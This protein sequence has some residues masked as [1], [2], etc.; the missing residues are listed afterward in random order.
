[1]NPLTRKAMPTTGDLTTATPNKKGWLTIVVVSG[2]ILAMAT[3]SLLVVQENKTRATALAEKHLPLLENTQ[4]LRLQLA[5]TQSILYA[6]YLTADR[7]GFGKQFIPNFANLADSYKQI[8]EQIPEARGLDAID[9]LIVDTLDLSNSFDRVMRAE[10]IDWDQARAVLDEFPAIAR[11]MDIESE[12]L[13]LWIRNHIIDAAQRSIEHTQWTLISVTLLGLASLLA[14]ALMIN[15]NR[16]RLE[17]LREQIRLVTF[18]ERNPFPVMSIRDSGTIAYSNN[19]ALDTAAKLTPDGDIQALLPDNLDLLLAHAREDHSYHQ[20]EYEKYSR[21]WS[22]GLHWLADFQ[23]YH[24]YLSDI[25]DRK[26]A[27]NRLTYLAYHDPLTGLPNRLQFNRDR[28]NN[29]AN[30]SV[31]A[32]IKLDHLQKVINT[33]GLALADKVLKA[34]TERLLDTLAQEQAP[35]HLY[36]FDGNLLCATFPDWR[37]GMQILEALRTAITP[38]F[39]I[40]GYEYFLTLSIGVARIGENA[41]R[42]KSATANKATEEILRQADSAMNVVKVSGG[43]GIQVYDTALDRHHQQQIILENDLRQALDRNELSLVFQPQLAVDSGEIIGAEALL[44]WQHGKLGAISPAVFIPMAEETGAIIDIGYWVLEQACRHAVCWK[45]THGKSIRVAVNIS[46]RQLFH[47]DLEA[48]VTRVLATTGLPAEHLELEI[49]ESTALEDFNTACRV[50][51]KLK[52]L[53][54]LLALDD[55][56]TGFSSL[57]Y[58][59]QLPVDTL[60][61]DKSFI[62]NLANSPQHQAIAKSIIGLAANLGLNV[63][64]EGI[65]TIDQ[66]ALL[67]NWQCDVIQGFWFSRPLSSEAFTTF[68]LQS[69]ESVTKSTIA[70]HIGIAESRLLSNPATGRNRSS[71]YTPGKE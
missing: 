50:L 3:L 36:R 47:T 61:I 31:V 71:T 59:A 22:L 33:G 19:S 27:E 46:P 64:A 43:N 8:Q 17:A 20:L 45:N 66:C 29:S 35:G 16:K 30:H 13:T 10:K 5:A 40:D 55:F 58:L 44:R 48:I 14:L 54:I 70:H 56:G 32:V 25:T 62:D 12:Q 63:I 41:I 49:T 7:E 53:G 51:G 4:N 2:L 60:K 18:P 42:S 6:Y 37:Q 26:T 68:L 69:S 67:A 52:S 65:E 15:H 34:F 1:M 9:S 11:Q 21:F 28:L 57:S 39:A 38:L 23:E 24:V